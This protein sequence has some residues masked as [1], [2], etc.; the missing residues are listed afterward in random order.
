MK[1][2]YSTMQYSTMRLL[3]LAAAALLP[4]CL[5][6]CG[7]S[8][9]TN[10]ANPSAALASR[11]RGVVRMEVKWPAAS[12]LIPL[13]ADRL[14]LRVMR[15][16]TVVATSEVIKPATSIVINDLPAGDY[17]LAAEAYASPDTVTPVAAQSAF[18]PVTVKAGQT[19]P[20]VVELQS[21]IT[22]LEVN[23][24]GIG[25]LSDQTNLELGQ[26]FQFTITPRNAS[27]NVVLVSPS[28]LTVSA[29]G[30]LRVTSPAYAVPNPPDI[31]VP[32]ALYFTALADTAVSGT[33]NVQVSDTEVGGTGRTT[34]VNYTINTPT[35]T[36]APSVASLLSNDANNNN[37]AYLAA[38]RDLYVAAFSNDVSGVAFDP[39]TAETIYGQVVIYDAQ[40]AE[41]ARFS[42]PAAPAPDVLVRGVAVASDVSIDSVIAPHIVGV[43]RTDPTTAQTSVDLFSYE[44]GAL[45]PVTGP[46]GDFIALAPAASN[47][48]FYAIRADGTSVVISNTGTV[49]ES[50]IVVP[51]ALLSGIAFFV[52][53][54]N[55]VGYVADLNTI[56]RFSLS[57]GADTGFTAPNLQVNEN[58]LV[59]RNGL[60]YVSQRNSTKIAVL[61]ATGSLVQEIELVGAGVT[62]TP[63]GVAVGLES[64]S[65]KPSILSLDK[66]DPTGINAAV[67]NRLNRSN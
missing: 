19:T 64:G 8:S 39:N 65:A 7:G 32:P 29:T 55:G 31:P 6:G 26:S 13:S 49:T 52:D 47:A 56:T 27:G 67:I 36:N 34:S 4:F 17:V 22:A 3:P 62:P 9:K 14:V 60:L 41:V 58:G 5:V 50:A 33:L 21:T 42:Y 44:N 43:L 20:V 16:T 1:T 24:L 54:Y 51:P 45:T 63:L 11:S 37:Q 10:S 66:F 2:R 61:N 28:S 53:Q 57:G 18:V 46:T 40:N 30:G 23:A 48:E 35:Y 12:R 59:L 38:S 15:G 25:V